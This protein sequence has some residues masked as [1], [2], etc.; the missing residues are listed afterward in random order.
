MW[1]SL[2]CNSFFLRTSE[3]NI[4]NFVFTSTTTTDLG[5]VSKLCHNQ[6]P[7]PSP[8]PTESY[9]VVYV[10]FD[11]KR[12]SS[13]GMNNYTK[14]YTFKNGIPIGYPSGSPLTEYES[15][16]DGVFKM[17]C[18]RTGYSSANV[19]N[20]KMST[21]SSEGHGLYQMLIIIQKIAQMLMVTIIIHTMYRYQQFLMIVKLS[22]Q[23][24]L[25]HQLEIF[26]IYM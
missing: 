2:L 26:V 13:D 24:R 8:T 19:Y 16:T 9:C 1:K 11:Y 12:T 7:T 14:S 10:N 21:T 4:P 18:L 3:I 5:R 6:T 22:F 23:H 15:V 17:L 25:P 20:I